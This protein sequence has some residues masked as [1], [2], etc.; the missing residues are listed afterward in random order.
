MYGMWRTLTN[1]D[2]RSSNNETYG[3]IWNEY[4]RRPNYEFFFHMNFFYGMNFFLHIKGHQGWR[5]NIKA[6][7]SEFV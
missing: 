2:P 3:T 1:I 6:K 4:M 5:G 7:S